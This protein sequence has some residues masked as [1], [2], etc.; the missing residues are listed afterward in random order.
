M[1]FVQEP[2]ETFG[3][4]GT[5]HRRTEQQSRSELAD[6]AWQPNLAHHPT[7]GSGEDEDDKELDPENQE[8]ML[9]DWNQFSHRDSVTPQTI[10][11]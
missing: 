9:F 5:E 10:T 7:E 8:L 6:D 2:V 4:G 1:P 11:G 3:P